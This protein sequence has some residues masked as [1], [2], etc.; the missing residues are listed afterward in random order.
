MMLAL[1]GYSLA[2][3]LTQDEL[4]DGLNFR[5]YGIPVYYR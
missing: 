4:F 5:D 3:A 1:I 2:I